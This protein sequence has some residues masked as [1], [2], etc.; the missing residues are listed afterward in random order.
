[1]SLSVTKVVGALPSSMTS[2]VPSTNQV[3]VLLEQLIREHETE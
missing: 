3:F 2:I 1:M